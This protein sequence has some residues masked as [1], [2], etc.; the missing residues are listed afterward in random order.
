MDNHDLTQCAYCDARIAADAPVYSI[1]RDDF[2]EGPEV[3]LCEACGSGQTPTCEQIWAKI[4]QGAVE[5]RA[6]MTQSVEEIRAQMTD[7]IGRIRGHIWLYLDTFGEG[8]SRGIFDTLRD[9]PD[10]HDVTIQAVQRELRRMVDEGTLVSRFA[11]GP[12]G[13]QLSR[14]TMGRTYYRFAKQQP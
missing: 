9:E 2:G 14:G 13:D 8:Y 3:P 5:A 4:G 6:V 10:G 11:P 1:H 7:R 12:H